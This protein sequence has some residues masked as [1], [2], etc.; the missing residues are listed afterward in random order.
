M[1]ANIDQ[2][3]QILPLPNKKYINGHKV[4]ITGINERGIV[5]YTPNGTYEITASS[6]ASDANQAFVIANEDSRDFWQCDYKSN[7]K[8]K[9]GKYSQYTQNPYTNGNVSSTYQGGGSTRNTWT[10]PVGTSKIVNVRGEWIQV[11]IPYN[12]YLQQYSIST[13]TYTQYNTFPIKFM[14]VASKDGLSWTELD[15]RNLNMD[16]LPT[17]ANMKKSFDINSADKYSYFR[18]IVN[19]MGP[20]IP[21]IKLTEFGLYG[22]TMITKNANALKDTF[23]TLSRSIEVTDDAQPNVTY[24]GINMYDKQYV[25]YDLPSNTMTQS[26]NIHQI[27]SIDNAETL[28]YILLSSIFVCAIF[29]GVFM[30]QLVSKPKV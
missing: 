30:Y 28:D 10:T 14:L 9:D 2:I 11:K 5:N 18:L 13:P 25:K 24:D 21:T 26:E 29:S 8:Y 4:T 17:D 3:I 20:N 12:A 16:E 22:T 27:Q 6:F 1:S 7:P 19:E 23:I 15:Q